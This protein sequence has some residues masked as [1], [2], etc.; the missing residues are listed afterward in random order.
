MPSAD[1][2]LF[3]QLHL[4]NPAPASRQLQ[5]QHSA[6]PQ[7]P[8]IESFPSFSK[9]QSTSLQQELLQQ[10]ADEA[11]AAFEAA[12]AAEGQSPA[13]LPRPFLYQPNDGAS[14]G[15]AA[16]SASV[17]VQPPASSEASPASSSDAALL[18]SNS[19]S[20]LQQQGQ[21][22]QGQQ[23]QGQQQQQ[24]QQHARK[25][26]LL[27]QQIACAR[28][29]GSAADVSNEAGGCERGVGSTHHHAS[30]FWRYMQVRVAGFGQCTKGWS[31]QL[32]QPAGVQLMSH[33]VCVVLVAAGC[34]RTT[35]CMFY[36][37]CPD[38]GCSV[39]NVSSSICAA[40][41]ISAGKHGVHA[42]ADPNMLGSCHKLMLL[43][44]S[45]PAGAG[46]EGNS[47]T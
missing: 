32:R 9:H 8:V 23:Q 38:A 13:D 46:G 14:A 24:Q 26:S 15:A 40:C 21:Q 36:N 11:A 18:L 31:I 33:A 22:Q 35:T 4:H 47:C 29:R 44:C 28:S 30:E 1:F 7:H 43:L 39:C 20:P 3:A 41:P 6:T 12:A 16:A 42:A 37:T 5:Q 17:Q 19:G 2:A 34:K 10:V 45:V 25:V 27:S